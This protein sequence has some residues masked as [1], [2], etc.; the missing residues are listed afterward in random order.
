V[1][2]LEPHFLAQLGVCAF[3]GVLFLQSGIDKVTDRAGNLD[4][5]RGHFAS[6]PLKGTV[7]LLLSAVTFFELAAGFFSAAGLISLLVHGPAWV[8]VV[9]IGLAC[10][11]LLMLFLGQRLAKDYAG[12]A[13]IA[14]YFAVAVLALLVMPTP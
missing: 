14:G 10:A 8:P 7:P 2:A 3:F 6:S 4:W 13:T 11:S 1:H 5:L 9:G 12:A